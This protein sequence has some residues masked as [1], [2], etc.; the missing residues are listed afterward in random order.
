MRP[1]S[2]GVIALP[3]MQQTYRK[4]LI[5]DDLFGLKFKEGV[6]FHVLE[7]DLQTE[8]IR[9]K[10]KGTSFAEKIAGYIEILENGIAKKHWGISRFSVLTLTGSSRRVQSMVDEVTAQTKHRPKLRDAFLFKVKPH[11]SAPH[12]LEPQLMPDLI[13]DPWTT[14]NGP[15]FINKI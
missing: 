2:L 4:K 14:A 3:L 12:W 15:V 11:L 10:G 6:R 13:T 8:P 7:T 9:R 1:S 5:P